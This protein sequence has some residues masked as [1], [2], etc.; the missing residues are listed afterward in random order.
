MKSYLFTI[1][2]ISLSLLNLPIV[3]DDSYDCGYANFS[4]FQFSDFSLYDLHYLLNV[5]LSKIYM[6]LQDTFP[7]ISLF[8][9]IYVTANIFS[10]FYA[11]NTLLRVSLNRNNL[12]FIAIFA[13]IHLILL[14]NIISISHTRYATVISGL[15]LINLFFYKNS[16]T[17]TAIH[18]VFFVFAFLTR[19]ESA[20]G[21]F[22]IVVVGGLL[23]SVNYIAL[24]KKSILPLLLFSLFFL[25]LSIHKQFTN[26]F[27]IK[28]EPDIEYALS[29]QRVTP[30]SA[31]KTLEDSV[32]YEMALNGIFID[33]AF[34]HVQFLNE[35]KI[36]S[37][38]VDFKKF[39]ASLLNILFF[40]EYYLLFSFFIIIFNFLLTYSGH[41]NA[42]LKFTLFN[43]F[44]FFLL[45]YLDYNV[46]LADRHIIG[47]QFL[48]L[49][50]GTIF[51]YK[52]K[53]RFF[54]KPLWFNFIFLLLF[55][56]A[57]KLTLS[58]AIG[59]Q[60]QVEKEV[61]CYIEVMQDF[62]TV[63]Q[64]KTVVVT[65]STIHLFDRNFSFFNDNYTQN[66]YLIYDMATNSILP[67]YL[68]YLDRLCQCRSHIPMEFFQWAAKNEV[69]F[70]INTHRSD[71][72]EKYM[73]VNYNAEMRFEIDGQAH[74][75]NV[76][77]CTEYS[78]YNDYQIKTVR[79][80]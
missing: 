49:M 33:T 76:P 26:R 5:L 64:D 21:A 15:A 22:L 27:E 66:N 31:M 32:R 30:I 37:I 10:L 67:R 47:I 29:T 18:C 17:A 1:I 57:S 62:E 59:N 35:I 42:A 68:N 46:K 69:I 56:L 70:L 60:F 6:Y 12:L 34:T 53:I 63:Y 38:A 77:D 3:F 7:S 43:L 39:V 51:F 71:I 9:V 14:E 74:L 73:K 72:I 23:L 20:M 40:Y 54:S 41:Y 55:I 36:N 52:Q 65:N 44:V 48:S 2:I 80:Y 13:A 19:P 61:N 79:F 28:I 75:H 24:F 25:S 45:A 11:V 58:N 16:K 50:V 4:R 8:P 78:I